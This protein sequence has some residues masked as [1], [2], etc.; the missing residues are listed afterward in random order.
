[1]VTDDA[2]QAADYS[3]KRPESF[4][5][6]IHHASALK[7]WLS[8]ATLQ[9]NPGP[10]L[11]YPSLLLPVSEGDMSGHSAA[12]LI[13]WRSAIASAIAARTPTFP[14]IPAAY[15]VAATPRQP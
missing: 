11:C 10:G 3:Q 12:I 1:M 5:F 6:P 14:N 8:L 9:E 15:A 13:F 4:C 7:W 2:N